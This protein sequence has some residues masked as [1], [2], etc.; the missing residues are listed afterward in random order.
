MPRSDP[1]SPLASPWQ[2][3][4]SPWQGWSH[5]GGEGA[6]RGGG[7]GCAVAR[8]VSWRSGWCVCDRHGQ[9]LFLI[10]P[11]SRG[12]SGGHGAGDSPTL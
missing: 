1:S 3:S 6:D 7:G 5:E 11:T 8:G 10:V 12:G 4:A 2:A 9:S